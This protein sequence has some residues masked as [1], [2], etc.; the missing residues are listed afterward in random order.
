VADVGVTMDARLHVGPLGGRQQVVNEVFVAIDAGALRHPS[1]TR[2]D[3]DRVV[4]AAKRERKRVK[5]PVVGLG[6]PFTDRIM[7]QVAIVADGDMVVAA[8]LP[9]IH[10]VLHDVTVHARLRIIAQVTGTVAVAKRERANTG[11]H[12]QHRRKSD[13]GFAETWAIGDG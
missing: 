2:L 7:W 12:A 1:I 13:R 11:E 4:V 10:V 5:K 3:L 6:H 8:L 9:R